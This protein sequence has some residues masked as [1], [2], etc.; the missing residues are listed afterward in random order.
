MIEDFDKLKNAFFAEV[1]SFKDKVLD[2]F[3]NVVGSPTDVSKTFTAHILEEVHFLRK[4]LKSKDEM[5]NSL[6]NQ[7]AKCNDMLELQKSNHSSS[8]SSSSSSSPSSSLL[9]SLPLSSSPSSSPSSSSSSSSSDTNLLPTPETIEKEKLQKN[10]VQN[11]VTGEHIRVDKEND[12]SNASNSTKTDENKKDQNRNNEVKSVVII[13][14]SMI[15]HLN[16]WDMSK[17][18]HKSECKVY[19]KSF[20]GAKTSCIKDYVKSSLRKHQTILYYTLERMTLIPI[21]LQKS[22]QKR[23]LTLQLH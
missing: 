7:L 3:E 1:K 16:G 8:S 18:V 11:T 17:K 5:I 10:N 21:K 20:P 15:K 13:G 22:L 9:L 23:L 2:S 14:D 19:V 4:Q 12:I 6:L